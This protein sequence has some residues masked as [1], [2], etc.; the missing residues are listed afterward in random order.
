M[1]FVPSEEVVETAE[2]EFRRYRLT[3]LNL[4]PTADIQHVGSTAVPGLLT[5]GDLDIQVRVPVEEFDP[6]KAKLRN[7]FNPRHENEIWTKAFASFEDHAN[8]AM[9]VG[10]QLTVT[11]SAFD[12]FVRVRDLLRTDM[13]L[14]NRYNQLK[15]RFEGKSETEYKRAKRKMFGPNGQNNLLK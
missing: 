11:G 5:K 14:L 12:E 1:H 13:E 10:I 7:G 2:D 15:R 8:P 3:L 4:I 6:A 9:P